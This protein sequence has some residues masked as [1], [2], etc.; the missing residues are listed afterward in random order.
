[1][2]NEQRLATGIAGLDTMLKGGFVPEAAILVRGA[3]GTG[4]TTLAFHYLLEGIKRGEPGLF[5]S[6]EEFPKSLYRDAASLGWNLMDYET[7]GL[8]QMMFTSPEV[9]LASL[10]T[11]D[12]PLMRIL[13]EA[14][15]KRVVVDSLTHFTRFTSD[16]HELR[17]TYSTVVNAFRREGMTTMFLGE[18]MR[19]DF[20]SSE[21][22]R[23]SFIVDCI[24]LL[25]YLEIE[26]AIQRAIVV[27]KMRSS[28]HDKSIHGYSI[29]T[30][31]ISVGDPL[32]GRVG[33]LSGISAQ[34]MI[35]TVQ[36][37]R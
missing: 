35:S 20:T 13:M 5:I 30:G 37:P 29:G 7:N 3:P 18:E 10:S 11:P 9:L 21:K 26:S 15:V 24:V 12:S 2:E 16:T 19:S 27:L 22:G 14:N 32:D 6:F 33:L 28:D 17:K 8:L 1:M 31:G 36:T 4:K 34:S 25:R 23:L